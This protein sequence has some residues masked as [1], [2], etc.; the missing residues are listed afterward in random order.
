MMIIIP[1][2]RWDSTDSSFPA[3]GEAVRPLT[4]PGLEDYS[5]DPYLTRAQEVPGEV[6]GQLASSTTS[7]RMVDM[8]KAGAHNA[9]RAL[10]NSQFV[11]RSEQFI[12]Y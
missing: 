4:P 1:F 6:Q 9:A 2:L 10:V 7:L 5:W 11:G 3:W 12:G 8:N